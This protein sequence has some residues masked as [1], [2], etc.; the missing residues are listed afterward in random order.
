MSKQKPSQSDT[1]IPSPAVIIDST[2]VPYLDE[3]L[4]GGLTRGALV[5]VMGAPGSGKTTLANQMAFTAAR[6]GR[7]ALVLT[8]I[9]EPTSK[10]I[11]HLR[12]YTFFDPDLIGD[13]VQFMSLQQ[14]L[15]HGLATTSEEVIATV[16]EA[17]ADF[18]VLDGFRG[19]RGADTDFQLARQ[20]LYDVGTTL[21][22]RG[23][24][25]IITSEAEPRDP[26]FFPETTTADVIIDLHYDLVGLHERRGIEIM[27]MR[28]RNPL[29]GM[30]GL[31]L[32][33]H[34]VIVSPRLEAQI[35]EQSRHPTMVGFNSSTT[36][37]QLAPDPLPPGRAAFGMPELDALL[38]G[39]L[40]R[41]TSTLLT[42]S[43]GTGK[44]L[45][46]LHF[47]LEGVRAGIPTLFL[48]FRETVGQLL[49]KADQFAMGTELR[50][51]LAADGKLATL[52]WEPVEL[53]PDRIT[54]EVIALIDRFGVQRLVVDSIAELQRA[55]VE[56]SGVSRVPNYLGAL[57]AALRARDV[58]SLFVLESRKVI[59][60]ELDFS[61]DALAILAENLLLLQQVSFDDQLHRVLSVIKMRFS[62]HDNVLR[63]FIIQ[64]PEGMHVL[65]LSESNSTVIASIAQ[66]QGVQVSSLP[67]QRARATD[68]APEGKP[69]HESE[70]K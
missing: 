4:R 53:N 15:S 48:T 57:L 28:G 21:S 33:E 24:T 7:R 36:V 29:P 42:G 9:S 59:A 68:A 31:G 13:M 38:G 69:G 58:T 2:G 19:I 8:A 61:A 39:G 17:Q 32:D 5:I 40:N 52:R 10:V 47:A 14:F 12:A 54:Q 20:F 45:L 55:V 46:A 30:H 66:Q 25:T 49:H 23:T 27:K 62:A 1:D 43:L 44:T 26:A 34:G 3:V 18:V 37:A 6:T 35:A 70:H 50:Q 60:S 64:P 41:Q 22:L 67:Q 56:S 65:A 11:E 63:E 51:A 16:R